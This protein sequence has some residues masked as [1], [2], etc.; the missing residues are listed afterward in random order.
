MK[1]KFIKRLACFDDSFDEGVCECHINPRYVMRAY[2]DTRIVI[3]VGGDDIRL[4][5]ESFNRLVEWLDD[6]CG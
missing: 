3:M 1:V 4:T 5:E 6:D 2:P